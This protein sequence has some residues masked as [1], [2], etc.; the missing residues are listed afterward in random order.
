MT[1]VLKLDEIKHL[2]RIPSLIVEIETG[3]GP[4]HGR[5]RK[6]PFTEKQEQGLVLHQTLADDFTDLIQVGL[7]GFNRTERETNES[8]Q[9]RSITFLACTLHVKVCALK[10]CGIVREQT[11]IEVRG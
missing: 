1:T 11:S 9:W 10:N 3:H 8:L 2:I 6:S 7:P 4:N 5:P